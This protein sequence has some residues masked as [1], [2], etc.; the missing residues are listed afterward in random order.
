MHPSIWDLETSFSQPVAGPGDLPLDF[1]SG[2]PEFKN[3]FTAEYDDEGEDDASPPRAFGNLAFSP[4][5]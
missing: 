2:S 3:C 5:S 1:M 4:E